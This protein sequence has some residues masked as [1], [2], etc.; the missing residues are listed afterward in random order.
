MIGL[1]LMG[2]RERVSVRWWTKVPATLEISVDEWSLGSYALIAW[3]GI[4][5]EV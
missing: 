1:W 5:C 4:V 2:G 3:N